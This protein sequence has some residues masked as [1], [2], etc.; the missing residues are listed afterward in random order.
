MKTTKLATILDILSDGKWHT[1]AEIER[2]SKMKKEELKRIAD[3]LEDYNFIVA[4]EN[5][6]KIK[7]Q[8]IAQKLLTETASS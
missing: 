6:R 4:D 5:K 2:E 7:L 8:E 3:F 1:I